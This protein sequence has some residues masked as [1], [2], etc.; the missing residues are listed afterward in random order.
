MHVSNAQSQL[1][2]DHFANG[3]WEALARQF[4][5]VVEDGHA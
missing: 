2:E 5:N 1:T 4:F 3:L